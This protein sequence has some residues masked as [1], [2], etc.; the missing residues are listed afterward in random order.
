MP[1]A[2]EKDP[3]YSPEPGRAAAAIHEPSA[4]SDCDHATAIGHARNES[5]SIPTAII[6]YLSA[7]TCAKSWESNAASCT[8]KSKTRAVRQSDGNAA[9]HAE[10]T[11]SAKYE[12]TC[13]AN[14][15]AIT[16]QPTGTAANYADGGTHGTT[17]DSRADAKCSKADNGLTSGAAAANAKSRYKPCACRLSPAC[18]QE[19]ST[20]KGPSATEG[21]SRHP[22]SR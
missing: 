7:D 4:I 5:E 9:T 10:R 13:A 12:P 15:G 21:C 8:P 3:R 11:A 18:C 2:I 6:S 14:P 20:R 1:N 17:R 22:P 16:I 19:V